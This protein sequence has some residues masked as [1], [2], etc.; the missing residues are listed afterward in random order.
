VSLTLFLAL[1]AA[2]AWW[3]LLRLLRPYRPCGCVAK[4]QGGP[5]SRC[6]GAR[7]VRRFGATAVHRFFWSVAG[8]AM[9]RRAHDKAENAKQKAGYPE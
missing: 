4:P 9:Q 6:K 1:A 8:E 7:Q 2:A 3:I 5:C